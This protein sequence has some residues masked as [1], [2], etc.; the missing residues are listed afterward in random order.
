MARAGDVI[1]TPCERAREVADARGSEVSAG[2]I[3][4]QTQLDWD[5]CYGYRDSKK[6]TGT[7]VC[8][9]K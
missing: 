3:D 5:L 2:R 6:Y 7:A 1:E 8:A 4:R 9:Q